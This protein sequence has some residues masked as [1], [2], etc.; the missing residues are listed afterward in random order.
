[1]HVDVGLLEQVPPVPAPPTP[2]ATPGR[3]RELR[4][5][6]Q[7]H[8]QWAHQADEYVRQAEHHA[9]HAHGGRWLGRPEAAGGHA[10]DAALE[11][12]TGVE[13]VAG[14]RAG[15]GVEA[16]AGSGAAAAKRVHGEEE[17]TLMLPPEV[18]KRLR[19]QQPAAQPAAPL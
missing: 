6:G 2:L 16:G 1:L 19:G 4:A 10:R 11:A 12:E 8:Q 5:L 17:I 9:A 7:L 15:A 18:H 3:L 14:P 13:V